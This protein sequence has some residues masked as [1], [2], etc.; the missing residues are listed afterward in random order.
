MDSIA[1]FLL[2]QM[3][4]MSN[5]HATF[6]LLKEVNDMSNM[7]TYKFKIYTSKKNKKLQHQLWVACKVYNHCIALHKRYW[8][9]YHKSLNRFRLNRHIT[10]LKKLDKFAYWN[11]L[12]SH[13]IQDITD[14]IDKGYKLFW[15][16]LKRK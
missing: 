14:R 12:Q 3:S 13:A 7:K 2:G 11:D 4:W 10:K 6:P 16:N 1:L 15:G 9:L 8:K 5:S